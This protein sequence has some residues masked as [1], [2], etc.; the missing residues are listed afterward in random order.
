MTMANM[1]ST[2][3]LQEFADSWSTSHSCRSQNHA[4][5]HMVPEN[6]KCAEMFLEPSSPFRNCFKQVNPNPFYHACASYMT[7]I[8]K[9]LKVL[10]DV[11][12]Y[13]VNQCHYNDVKLPIPIRCSTH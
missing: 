13:Y 4:R 2:N 5:G 6:R 10:C 11:S 3:D 8:N 9:P 7:S 1:R 12:S